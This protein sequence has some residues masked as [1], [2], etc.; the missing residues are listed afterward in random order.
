MASQTTLILFKTDCVKKKLCGDVLKRFESEG[1]TVR[2]IKMMNLSEEVLK[3]HYA[4]VAHLPFF[5]EIVE[6][7]QAAPVVALALEG[8]NVIGKVR[9]LLGPTDSTKAA[10]GTIR[11]DHGE[12]MMVNVCH[13]SDSE[14]NAAAELKRFFADGELFDY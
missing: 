2:G 14:E 7:M 10:A 12:N 8:E 5:P 6:F 4:H 9:D 3:E 13:A 1:F 11:G